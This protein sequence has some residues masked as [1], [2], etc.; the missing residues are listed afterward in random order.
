MEVHVVNFGEL[1]R[2]A[3]PKEDV[4]VTVSKGKGWE[5]GLSPFILGPCKLYAA[6]SSKNME[7]AW[8]FS[9]VYKH[10]LDEE[11]E[12]TNEYWKWATDGW[13]DGWAHRYPAGK[14]AIPEFSYW[15]GERLGYTDARKRI[16]IPLYRDAVRETFAFKTLKQKY[17]SYKKMNKDLYLV[18]YDA[19]MHK[20]LGMTYD[21][22]VNYEK[23]KMGHAFVLAMMLEAPDYVDTFKGVSDIPKLADDEQECVGCGAIIPL[24][25]TGHDMCYECFW[26]PNAE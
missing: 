19:Y 7:N 9:K 24:D 14:G 8:Q 1:K 12:L 4:V 21:Q 23:K 26:G 6:H 20:F 13:H 15:D 11:G 5:R 16:Y 18:D 2:E 17:D 3:P 25:Y 10:H 22:V